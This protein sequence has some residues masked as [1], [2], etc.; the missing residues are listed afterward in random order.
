[1]HTLALSLVFLADIME[2]VDIIVEVVFD[3]LK[4][5]NVIVSFDVFLEVL[6]LLLLILETFWNPSMATI[7]ALN[8]SNSNG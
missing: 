6:M 5:L 2:V 7:V 3:D 4:F 1:M 8:I